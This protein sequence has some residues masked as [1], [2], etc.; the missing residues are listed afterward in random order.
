MVIEVRVLGPVEVEVEGAVVRPGRAQVRRVLA[1]LAAAE[2]RWVSRDVLEVELWPDTPPGN[3]RTALNV[4]VA[5]ARATA[6]GSDH[7]LIVSADAGYRLADDVVLDLAT[8]RAAV[9]EAHA[10]EGGGEPGAAADVLGR[11][12]ATWRGEPYADVE[13]SVRIDVARQGLG[14]ERVDVALRQV[15]LL[16]DA[17]RA[18]EAAALATGL[19]QDEVSREDVVVAAMRALRLAG[20][21]AEALRLGDRFRRALRD[22]VGLQPSQR[23]DDEEQAALRPGSEPAPPAVRP[24]RAADRAGATPLALAPRRAQQ[25]DAVAADVRSDLTATRGRTTLVRGEPGAGRTTFLAAV[26]ARL[27]AGEDAPRVVVADGG[28]V[29]VPDLVPGPAPMPGREDEALALLESLAASAGRTGLVLVVDDADRSDARSRL[30]LDAVARH[31]PPGVAVVATAPSREDDTDDVRTV[32]LAPLSAEDVLLAV[33]RD[34]PGLAAGRAR[35]WAEAIH[36]WCGGNALWTTLA[37]RELDPGR[38][39]TDV[40]VPASAASTVRRRLSGLD[41]PTRELLEVAAVVGPDIDPDLVALLAE[42]PLDQVL[43]TLGT[44]AGHELVERAA[45]PGRWRFRHQLVATALADAVDLATA[46]RWRG[47]AGAELARQPGRQPDAAA[48]LVAAV[49]VVDRA[50]AVD[51]AERGAAE[52]MARGEHERAVRLLT[53]ALDL[54]G[55]SAPPELRL[56]WAAALERAGRAE[57]AEEA[58]DDALERAADDDHASLVA[59]GLG[60]AGHGGVIGGR[61]GRRR[62]L[63]LAL[64]RLPSGHHDRGRVAAELALELVNGQLPLDG[65]LADLVARTAADHADA[66]SLMA[67]RLLLTLD[68]VDHGAGGDAAAALADACLDGAAPPGEAAA[69]LAVAVGVALSSGRW[70]EG[71]RWADELEHLGRRAG[72]A[73]ARWQA[74][75]F[76]TVISE[77]RD[78][79]VEA[80]ASAERAL[81]LGRRLDIADAEATFGL[82][83]LGRALRVGSLASSASIITGAADRY[84]YAIWHV[85]AGLAEADAGREAEARSRLRTGVATLRTERIHFRPATLALAILLADRLDDDEAT[86][87]VAPALDRGGWTFGVIGYGGPCIGPMDRYRAIAAARLG[88]DEGAAAHRAAARARCAEVGAR[89]WADQVDP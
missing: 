62:R 79:T 86:A 48:L 51:A 47:R 26:A 25:A 24:A 4:A 10:L 57:E 67:R 38:G 40:V 53:A 87:E 89:A 18:A 50:E 83:L 55:P 56:R 7:D 35:R 76:R 46:A 73:R 31:R 32:M 80:D 44:A 29:V 84:R 61:P 58:Y 33:R 78:E 65:D 20:R 85:L 64:R 14:L 59:A 1:L 72:V 19:T 63:G 17:G 23:L 70:G 11:A 15:E 22:G 5:R 27:R 9:A 66:G 52:L 16:T 30:L 34:W 75:A 49:P 88:D 69:G 12:L 60:G 21:A 82:H 2:G 54:A 8:W 42:R 36:R 74:E 77:A 6:S 41:A 81:H 3:T 39:P 37:V 45:T 13:G 28:Q 68:E 71:E 43:T